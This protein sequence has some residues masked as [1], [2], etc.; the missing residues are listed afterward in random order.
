MGRRKPAAAFSLFSFQD[1]ITSVTAILILVM[2]LLAVEL[3]RKRQGK[4]AADP[5]VTRRKLEKVVEELE[6]T[7][8]RIREDIAA[9]HLA[10]AS[11]QTREQLELQLQ[12]STDRLDQA[13]L[14][15]DDALKTLRIAER[16]RV[17]A[18][19]ALASRDADRE[20]VQ[21]LTANV[22][23]D[24]AEAD[25]LERENAS[26]R[27]RQ[28]RRRQEVEDRPKSGTQLVFNRPA[29][30]SRRP[31]LVELS[32]EGVVAVMLGTNNREMFGD[33]AAADGPLAAWISGLQPAGD[34]CLLLIRPSAGATLLDD[35]ESKLVRAGVQYGLDFIGEDQVVRDG[36]AEV[37]SGR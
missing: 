35:V 3:T 8:A 18:E 23:E 25:Q 26:E 10:E 4:A 17:E 1:I 15:R 21:S 34:Y 27:Q 33:P 7:A 13:R 22:A 5:G 6:A 29:D 31:W 24:R 28:A 20:L 9:A 36:S 11:Y 12:Q 19:A 14:Q 2:L 30:S 37:T 32:S 16:A